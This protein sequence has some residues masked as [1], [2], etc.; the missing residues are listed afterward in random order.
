M[1][2][3]STSVNNKDVTSIANNILKEQYPEGLPTTLYY[4]EFPFYGMLA[5][6]PELKGRQNLIP[7]RVS[8]GQ[9]RSSTFSSAVSGA[10]EELYEA[11]N[12][13]SKQD[14]AYSTISRKLLK[15]AN[16]NT[17]SFVKYLTEVVNGRIRALTNSI[18]VNLFLDGTG[19]RGTIAT[20]GI[21][22]TVLTLS[23]NT[24][25]VKFEVGQR[26]EVREAGTLSNV[27][28]WAGD[29]AFATVSKVDR[30]AGTV[31]FD[32]SAAGGTDTIAAGDKL[33][34]VGD[35][36]ATPTLLLGLQAWLPATV[37]GS[38]NFL[39]VNR[40]LDRTRLAGHYRDFSSGTIEEALVKGGREIS[41]EAGQSPDVILMNDDDVASLLLE[42][43]SKVERSEKVEGEFSWSSYKIHLPSGSADVVADRNCPKGETFML[44]LNTWKL[45]HAPGQLIEIVDDDGHILQR[46]QGDGFEIRAASYP[47]LVCYEPVCNGRFLLPS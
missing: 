10:S 4:K 18:G 14:Y 46:H 11:W 26:I 44:K 15:E 31:T 38:D 30:V 29:V 16:D 3:P 1:A 23:S 17:A 13:K 35:Y 2:F 42:M 36:S 24:D 43:G 22:A 28:D 25:G 33:F 7:M 40:S 5:K 21:A 8:F 32:T 20:G 9:G 27:R 45:C 47:E 19:V 41:R 6:S 37:G 39:G 34:V 12:V